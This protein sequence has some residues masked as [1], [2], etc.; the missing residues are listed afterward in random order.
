MRAVQ[1]TNSANSSIDRCCLGKFAENGFVHGFFDQISTVTGPC[2]EPGL[3][4]NRR[5]LSAVEAANGIK[6]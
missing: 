2:F 6:P 4:V 3:A 1:P 5:F